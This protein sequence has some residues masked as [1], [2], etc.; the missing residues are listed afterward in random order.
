MIF[1]FSFEEVMRLSNL[2]RWG[3]VEM[4]RSQSVAEHSYNVVMISAYIVDKLPNEIKPA[5]LREIVVNWSLVHDLPELVTGDIPTP[6]KELIRTSLD[7]AEKDL[8]PELSL[9]K[10]SLCELSRVIC[11]IADLM[12]A[13]QFANKFC[14]DSRKKEIIDEMKWNVDEVV[15]GQLDVNTQ[16]ALYKV[17]KEI[18]KEEK[19]L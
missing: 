4:S 12:E 5:G 18:W 3:I 14:V 9:Y 6:I 2:K 8:F 17:V 16:L 10:E 1:D 19:T 13:I 7:G 15:D 11:K